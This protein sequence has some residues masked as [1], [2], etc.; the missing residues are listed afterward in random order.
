MAIETTS[1]PIDQ[2][3]LPA[4]TRLPSPPEIEAQPGKQPNDGVIAA[5]PDR[6]LGSGRMPLFRN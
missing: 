6:R 1:R 3:I 2:A 4:E 5:L